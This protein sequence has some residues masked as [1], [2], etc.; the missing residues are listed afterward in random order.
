MPAPATVG[1]TSASS[2]R[3]TRDPRPVRP[4]ELA[5]LET[6]VVCAAE[7]S[8]AAA[9][10]RLGISRPAVAKR[11]AN[12]EAIAGAPLLH[13]GGRGVRLTDAG[14]TLLTGARRMLDER[15]VLMR[16][17]AE[18]R[19][20]GRSQI[21]GLRDLLG[22]ATSAARAAARPEARLAETE[23]VLDLFLRSSS[24]AVAIS[25]LDRGTIHEVNDAFCRLTG[26]SR[27][28]LVE[29]TPAG[30]WCEAGDYERLTEQ[31]R[32][33]GVAER[34]LVRT[35]RPDGT[36]R[37]GRATAHFVVL[38]GTRQLLSTVEDITDRHRLEAERQAVTGAQGALGEL[39]AR[40]LAGRPV[41]ES[42]GHILPEL[43]RSGEFATGL[44]WDATGS[45]PLIVDGEAPPADLGRE[46]GRGRPL[47]SGVM[48]L[49]PPQGTGEAGTGWAVPLGASDHSVVLL[50]GD[51]PAGF[52]QEVFADV[53]GG[54]ARLVAAS[55]RRE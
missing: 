43:R 1:C 14:A 17:L 42:V 52:S 33:T 30:S 27:E 28:E 15:D 13:R 5:E 24:T 37:I 23:R 41:I 54:L 48:R 6:L 53:L 20:E 39:A 9:A 4:P 50:R 21:A 40:L 16:L 36:V 2:H 19:G 10:E 44:L 45:R 25:D 47:A 31:V 8:L 35:H 49:F 46:L 22:H 7:G 18:I 12:L 38:A 26:R 32:S 3:V 34:V 11:I 55:V 51:S 29:G